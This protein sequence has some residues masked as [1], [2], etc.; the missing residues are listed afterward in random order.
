MN[1]ARPDRSERLDRLAAEFALGT[2]PSR[3]RARL[4]RAAR[5]EPA[6]A[7][8]IN[9]WEQRLAGLAAAIPHVAVSCS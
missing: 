8:A 3:A 4:A 5:S 1:L 2:L 7:A 9:E 6:V